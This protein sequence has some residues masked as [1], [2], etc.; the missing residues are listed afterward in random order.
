MR[1]KLSFSILILLPILGYSQ[2]AT[3]KIAPFINGTTSVKDGLIE[4]GPDFNWEKKSAGNTFI[5]RPAIR[6][7]LTNK[8]DNV[9]QIDRFSSTW[10]SILSFQFV[11]DNTQVSGLVSRHSVAGQLEYGFSGF[12][13]YPTGDKGNE[14]KT[15]K[16]SYAFE[17]KYVGFLTKG[18]SFAWQFSPQFRLRYS[19]DWRAAGEVGIVN[20]PNGNGVVTVSNMIIDAPSVR[21]T[22]SPAFSLQMYPGKGAFSY[23]PTIYYDFIGI[24]GTNNPFDNLNRLRIESWIF[25]YPAIANTPN[26]KIGVTPFISIRTTGYDSFNKIE[27]GGMITI[28]FGST[29]LQFL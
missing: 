19:Y 28:K 9:I 18:A 2:S 5:L 10:R 3:F 4:I 29:M 11:K 13:Y 12:K 15:G 1:K 20:P 27:Y 17:L 22:F 7:P 26:V 24:K 23:S 6:M 14:Q 25:F 21:P 16:N 8:A